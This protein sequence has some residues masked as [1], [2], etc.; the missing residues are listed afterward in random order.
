[1]STA[2]L[3]CVERVRILTLFLGFVHR[4]VGLLEHG[5]SILDI[6]AVYYADTDRY[7]RQAVIRVFQFNIDL[8]D[9]RFDQ[10]ARLYAPVSSSCGMSSRSLFPTV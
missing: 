6:P 10:P 2:S 1:M 7:R 3:F 9:L 5:F 8:I 4:S